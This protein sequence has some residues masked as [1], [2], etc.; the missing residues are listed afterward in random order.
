[1]SKDLIIK[2]AVVS[3]ETTVKELEII[4]QEACDYAGDI[5]KQL[6][7][8]LKELEADR[9]SITKPINDSLKVINAKYKPISE[10][11][12]NLITIL[13]KKIKSFI[14]AEEQKRKEELEKAL[15]EEEEAK[16]KIAEAKSDCELF[17]STEE[18]EELEQ[19]KENILAY[20]DEKIEQQEDNLKVQAKTEFSTTYKIKKWTYK[21]ENF[22]LIPREFLMIDDKLIK[23]AIRDGKRN[24][25]GL[26]IFEDITIG[27]R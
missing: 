20:Y 7:L 2:K 12:D 26:T 17:G 5:L 13:N 27:S 22:D 10:H 23:S 21:V 4:S 24:I 3:I 6:K 1:M 11:I 14:I 9:V 15:L 18:L 19:Q 8:N 25:A 16:R